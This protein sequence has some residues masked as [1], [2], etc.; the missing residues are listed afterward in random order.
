MHD[1]IRTFIFCFFFLAT[2]RCECGTPKRGAAA[3]RKSP[4]RARPPLA[5]RAG[6]QRQR[7]RQCFTRRGKNGT[8]PSPRNPLLCT[9]RAGGR[10]RA[11]ASAFASER[12]PALASI[13][14]RVLEIS[15][16]PSSPW[17]N[18]TRHSKQYQFFLF[19]PPPPNP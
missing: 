13:G 12:R 1:F 8:R 5:R 11:A 4:V 16:Q 15:P 9:R 17:P 18:A 2:V 6:P 19:P 3:V 7:H 10:M 14:E